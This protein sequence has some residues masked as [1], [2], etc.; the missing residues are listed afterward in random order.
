MNNLQFLIPEK[1]IYLRTG[2][3]II[4]I[5][6]LS[7]STKGNLILDIE[8]LSLFNFLVR[9]PVLLKKVKIINNDKDELELLENEVGSIESKFPNNDSL[10]DY[11]D[12]YQILK[13][14]AYYRFIE[15]KNY[16]QSFYY[17][18]TEIGKD[19]SNN[20]NSEYFLRVK[21]LCKSLNRFRSMKTNKLKQMIEFSMEG[22]NHE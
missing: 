4:I 18:I 20:L 6:E 8:K 1:D 11:E 17:Y 2:R 10:F 5:S 13:I 9:Y 15:G 22:N 16:N 21:E 3:I 7:Y 14:A 19:F 12:L